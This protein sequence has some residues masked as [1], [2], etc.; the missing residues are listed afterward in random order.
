MMA[1]LNC[2]PSACKTDALP[3]ELII[4]ASEIMNYSPTY[5]PNEVSR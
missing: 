1:D 4:Q 2:R 3:I 5:T